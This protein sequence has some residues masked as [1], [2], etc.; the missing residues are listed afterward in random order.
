MSVAQPLGAFIFT[1]LGFCF[2]FFFDLYR[3]LRRASTPGQLLTAATDLLFWFTYT[4]W[5]YIVLL[6]VNLGEVRVFLLLC[7]AL[8]AGAYF[9]WLSPILLSAWALVFHRLALFLAWLSRV[10]EAIMGVLLWPYHALVLP[11]CSLLHW[12][13]KPFVLLRN[14]LLR[15]LKGWAVRLRMALQRLLNKFFNQDKE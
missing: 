13:L 12:L 1:F 5:V 10:I 6:R 14:W 15:V 7:L 2:G 9:Y 8:G 4:I 11:L 3:V